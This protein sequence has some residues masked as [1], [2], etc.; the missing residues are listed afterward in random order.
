MKKINMIIPNHIQ[1]IMDEL[2]LNGYEVY[3]VGGAVR[4]SIMKVP[5]HDYDLSTS[6]TI[7]EMQEVFKDYV[8]INNNGLKHNTITL[9]YN[10]ENV[11][12][13]SFK[14]DDGEDELITTDLSHRDFTINAM[15]YNNQVGLVDPFLGLSDMEKGIIRTVGNPIDRFNEDP[16]R[17]LRAIRFAGKFNFKITAETKEE[18][19]NL[20]ELLEN[21]S[22]ERIKTELEGIMVS[23]NIREILIEYK[24]IFG[25]IIPELIP[26][27]DFNQNHR[28]HVHDV[29]THIAYVVGYTKPDF[30]LRMASL[31]HDIAKPQTYTEILKD[32]VI[33][34]RFLTHPDVGSL[35]AQGIMKRYR[36]SNDEITEIK[37][38]I[39]KH[40]GLLP[41]TKKAVR[42]VLVQAPNQSYDVFEKLIDLKNA[43]RSDHLYL[44]S[45]KVDELLMIAKTIIEENECLKVTDLKINGYDLMKLGLSGKSIKE[46]LNYLLQKVINEEL[47][48]ETNALLEE[49]KNS[50]MN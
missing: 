19:F 1:K 5:V 43:D 41:S 25:Q 2:S 4:D 13:S 48:N 15:A 21:V 27:F 44:D 33:Q 45:V 3:V 24:S 28:C 50:V 22:K 20:M 46:T 23:D 49:V 17:I 31:F 40:D 37:Y 29:Y 47:D 7:Q 30:R 16:L 34:G 11:E 32:G 36:F 42:K 39:E 6:A 18:I 10:H 38:L 12:I 9:R 35:I 26:T 8:I 14:V